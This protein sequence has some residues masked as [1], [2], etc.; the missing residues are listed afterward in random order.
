MRL[1]QWIYTIPLRLRSLF[2]RITVDQE[3]EEELRDH[4]EHQTEANISNGMAPDEARRRALIALGG[5][6]QRK[7]QCREAHRV[8]WISDL[9]RDLGYGLR[10]MRRNP[11]FTIAVL[12]SRARHRCQYCHF[13]ARI[14]LFFPANCLAAKLIASSK[15]AR[16]TS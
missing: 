12:S 13:Y 10:G 4:I 7:Q 2:C 5:L 8:S 9:A 16:K 11:S 15:S 3:I 6:E 1:E 14:T